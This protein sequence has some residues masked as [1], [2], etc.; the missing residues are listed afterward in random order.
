MRKPII[1]SFMAVAAGKEATEIV[2]S[3]KFIGVGA[4]KVLCVNPNKENLQK[5]FPNR[6]ILEEPKYLIE[7]TDA[8]KARGARIDFYLESIPEKNNGA[9]FISKVSYFLYEM[10]FTNNDQTKVQVID[11]FGDTTWLLKEDFK[12][13]TLP[14]VS[15]VSVK[16]LRPAYRGEEELTKFIKAFL[17]IPE[18][19]FIK[20]GAI[21]IN[22]MIKTDKDEELCY[23]QLE[24]INK[25]FNGDFS[26]LNQILSNSLNLTVKLL[27]GVKMTVDNKQYTDFYSRLP[28]KY[29]VTNYNYLARLLAEDKTM[30]RYA[31]TTFG[32]APDFRF[33]KFELTPTPAQ[34]LTVNSITESDGDFPDWP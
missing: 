13:K 14:E 23:A 22:P 34:E 30:G 11:A 27:T 5:L 4:Y 19:T 2:P 31:N 29:G 28:L 7:K 15:R 10:P 1:I 26:E 9:E 8:N 25:Y 6:E 16:G 18:R 20:E 12:T 24:K 3:P 17:N 32:E 21:T 33:V